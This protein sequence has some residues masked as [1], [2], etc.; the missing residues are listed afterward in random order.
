MSSSETALQRLRAAGV[1]PT[2]SR[3]GVF[4][5]LESHAGPLT[6]KELFRPMLLRGLRISIVTV[7]RVI[8]EFEDGGLILRE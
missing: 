5:I 4:Q 7:Y 1:R 3:I 8:H 6:A 2:S